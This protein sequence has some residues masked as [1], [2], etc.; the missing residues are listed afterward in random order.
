MGVSFLK[1]S[2]FQFNP[3][4]NQEVTINNEEIPEKEEDTVKDLK[5]KVIKMA[6][7]IFKSIGPGSREKVYQKALEQFFH[8]EGIVVMSEKV[9]PIYFRDEPVGVGFADIVV[10]GK[11]VLELKATR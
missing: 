10:Q 7:L 8:D 9:V 2:T 3:D 11:L 5:R 4:E 1:M 6:S